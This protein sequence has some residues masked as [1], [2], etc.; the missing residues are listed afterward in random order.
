LFLTFYQVYRTYALDSIICFLIVSGALYLLFGPRRRHGWLRPWTYLALSA[1]SFSLAFQGVLI[2]LLGGE[3]LVFSSPLHYIYFFVCQ[4]LLSFFWSC[5]LLRG[6]VFPKLMYILILVAFMQLYRGVCAPLYDMEGTMEQTL[7]ATFDLATAVGLYV[8]LVGMALLFKRCRVSP[9]TRLDTRT[10]VIMLYILVSLLA[11]MLLPELVS[12]VDSSQLV[13]VLI[14]S[15]LP[16]I[17]YIFGR[18]TQNLEEQ[19]HMEQALEKARAEWTVYERS[20]ELR[21]RIREERHELKNNYFHL[22]VLLRAGDTEAVESELEERVGLISDKMRE[23]D[24]GVAYLDYLIAAKEAA[25]KKAGVEFGVE[26]EIVDG[27]EVDEMAAGTVLSNLMDNAIEASLG[28][29]H[30]CVRVHMRYV[31]GYLY[32]KVSNRVSKDVIALNPHLHTTKHDKRAH[33]YG[34]KIVRKTLE[35]HEGMLNVD[36]KDG[37]FVASFMLPVEKSGQV[38]L[39]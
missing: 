22:L 24:T 34:L 4:V 16:L 3:A 10:R 14:L 2:P 21:E 19:A 6:D 32:G 33:G 23:I 15:D 36:V 18:F 28:E 17:Y 1:V 12:G 30:P 8:C 9:S 25:A 38:R 29:E 7:Y 39:A 13:I 35:E 26:S 5:L 27:F 11:S 20:Q 31:K 37:W